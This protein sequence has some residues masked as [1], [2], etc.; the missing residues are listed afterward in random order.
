MMAMIAVGILTGVLDEQVSSAPS[1]EPGHITVTGSVGRGRTWDDEG[2]I[3]SGAFAGGG[4]EWKIRPRLSA[5]A[6]VERLA[7]ERHTGEDTLVFSGRTIFAT[8]EMKYRF[9]DRGV[10]PFVAGGYGVAL[11]A[12]ELTQ[13]FGPV[14]TLHRT[15]HS[16]TATGGGGIEV[17]IGRRLMLMPELRILFCQPNQDFAPWSAIRGGITVG[18]RF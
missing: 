13:R 11:Y 3:G 10:V 17:P 8:A 5:M 2:S 14:I 6:R 9:G 7:H 1:P 15:S 18:W 16:G 12:G 4:V